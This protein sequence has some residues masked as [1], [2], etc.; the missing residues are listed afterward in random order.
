MS[1]RSTFA[2]EAMRAGLQVEENT[3]VLSLDIEGDFLEFWDSRIQC[4][5]VE[6]TREITRNACYVYLVRAVHKPTAAVSFKVGIS[7]NPLRRSKSY[8]STTPPGFAVDLCRSVLRPSKQNAEKLER[9]I[10]LA[11]AKAGI[12]S[13]GEWISSQS[14]EDFYGR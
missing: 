8:V 11:A 12:W 14:V 3:D 1:D 5:S 10:L 9:S 13:H 6:R 2:I 7:E 4:L